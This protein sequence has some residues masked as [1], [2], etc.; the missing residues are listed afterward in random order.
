MVLTEQEFEEIEK[1][2]QKIKLAQNYIPSREDFIY[3]IEANPEKYTLF[4]LWYSEHHPVAKNIEEKEILRR[5]NKVTNKTI[6][7]V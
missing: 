7:I 3:F 1:N 5:I 6:Q 2:F 4:L